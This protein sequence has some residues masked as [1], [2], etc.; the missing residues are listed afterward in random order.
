MR[1]LLYSSSSSSARVLAHA[2]MFTVTTYH[3]EQDA[4]AEIESIEEDVEQHAEDENGNPE[5]HHG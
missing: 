5:R 3:A 2:V 1:T 4:D